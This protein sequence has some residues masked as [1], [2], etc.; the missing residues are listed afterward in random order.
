MGSETT[1]QLVH[2]GH[3][4]T[5]IDSLTYASH[6][7]NLE[8]VSAQIN[9]LKIDICDGNK[10]SEMLTQNLYD[11]VINFAAETHVDNS[12]KSPRIFL[13]TNV[14]GTFNLLEAAQKYNFR[15]LQVSTDEVYGSTSEGSFTEVSSFNPSSPY[16]A[17]KAAAEMF[18]NAFVST[19]GLDIVG[20]RCSN[21]YGPFQNTEKLIPTLIRKTIDNEKLPLYGNGSNVREWIH[22]SDSSRAI[23]AVLLGGTPGSFY[24][25]SSGNFQ[26]NLEVARKVLDYF[27]AQHS[28]IEF[29]EDRPGHD[30]RYAID[31]SKIRE[32]LGWYP[33]IDFDSGLKETID[34]YS[35]NVDWAL[36]NREIFR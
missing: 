25:I 20:V 6:V 16:S 12:I 23:I 26:E 7:K 2:L 9:F 22:V 5:V 32:E 30:F 28:Q 34:W 13:E 17:S 19:Y 11:A 4:V 18:V 1:R 8:S 36:R 10:L 3:E 27:G 35:S 33:E 29:V 14:I 31:S 15:L 24:N 21:N